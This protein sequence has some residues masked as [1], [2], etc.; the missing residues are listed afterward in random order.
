MDYVTSTPTGPP[1]NNSHNHKTIQS[2][3]GQ[4]QFS[5]SYRTSKSKQLLTVSK[6]EWEMDRTFLKPCLPF[7]SFVSLREIHIYIFLR[8]P[9]LL[10][11]HRQRVVHLLSTILFVVQ[12][13]QET[14]SER[15]RS[16]E[17]GY[18]LDSNWRNRRFRVH[19]RVARFLVSSPIGVLMTLPHDRPVLQVPVLLGIQNASPALSLPS[20][21]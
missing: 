16:R 12:G 7:S 5:H 14:S 10:T 2:A 13:T 15:T 17:M 4:A 11:G 9:S 6:S 1:V 8:P 18:L 3:Q 19:S 20:T 21:I